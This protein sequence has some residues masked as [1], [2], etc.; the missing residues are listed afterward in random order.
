MGAVRGVAVIFK[1]EMGL[2]VLER[3]FSAHPDSQPPLIDKIRFVSLKDS[4]VRYI[5]SDR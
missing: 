5:S 2:A 4:K 1:D 3:K